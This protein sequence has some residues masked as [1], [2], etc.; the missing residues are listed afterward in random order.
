MSGVSEK[1]VSLWQRTPL[2]GSL[3]LYF[4]DLTRFEGELMAKSPNAGTLNGGNY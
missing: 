1:K 4:L 2:A 3:P